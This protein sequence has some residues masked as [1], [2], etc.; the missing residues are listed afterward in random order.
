M[1][2]KTCLPNR[3]SVNGPDLLCALCDKLRVLCGKVSLTAKVA[4]LIAKY[5]E[6]YRFGFCA[7]LAPEADHYA[8]SDVS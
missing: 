8:N 2:L 7:R 5:A 6:A 3:V 1:S 4:E